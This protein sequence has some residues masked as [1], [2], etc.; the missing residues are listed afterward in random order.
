M[1]HTV[2]TEPTPD[3]RTMAMLAHI[4]QL[5]SGFIAPLIIYL[6]KRDSRFVGFH[7]LQALIWQAFYFVFGMLCMIV[8]FGVIFGSI[9]THPASAA[10]KGPPPTAFFILFGLFWLFWM[11]GWLLTLI[12]SIVYGVKANHGE[13]AAY[14]IIGRWARRL[15]LQRT[16]SHL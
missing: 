16:D 8:W 10:S 3:E 15:A 12:L 7:A 4:L 11:G 14:P 9:A 5:F 2:A 6:V 13:W 1:E